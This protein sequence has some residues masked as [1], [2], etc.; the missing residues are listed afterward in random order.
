MPARAEVGGDYDGNFKEFPSCSSVWGSSTIRAQLAIRESFVACCLDCGRAIRQIIKIRGTTHHEG[1]LVAS[2]H[3]VAATEEYILFVPSDRY[4]LLSEI[5][6]VGQEPL[7]AGQASAP[8][9]ARYE[10]N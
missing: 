8:L 10:T 6:E 4:L 5:R 7:L 2:R 1:V 3:R 9:H